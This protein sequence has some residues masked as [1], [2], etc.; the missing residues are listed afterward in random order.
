MTEKVEQWIYIQFCVKLEHSSAETIGWF[1][2]AQLWA[3]GD[4]QLHHD[5]APAHASHLVQRFLVKRQIT[6]MTQPLPLQPKFGPLWLLAFPQTKITFEREEISLCIMFLIS[7]IFF[8]KYLYFSQYVAEYFL[9]R[10]CMSI[11][12]NG[13]TYTHTHSIY[14][15]RICVHIYISE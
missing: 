9:D 8:N 13:Y 12:L 4:W 14:T 6:L 15:H 11:I 1:G 5:N 7:C 3:A 10:L 2:R